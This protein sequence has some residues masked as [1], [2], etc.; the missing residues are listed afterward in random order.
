MIDQSLNLPSRFRYE[1]VVAKNPMEAGERRVIAELD[2][3]GCIRHF[4]VTHR[5]T[6]ENRNFILRIWWDDEKEPSVECP[7]PDFFGVHNDEVYYPINSCFLSVKDRGGFSCCF[8]MPF[9]KSARVEVEALEESTFIY[10]LDWHKYL[11]DAMEE[12]LRFHASWRR[13]NPA[14]AW[15]EDFFVIDAVGRGRLIGF[16]LGVRLRSDEHRWSHAGSENLY[17]DGEATGQD[18][19]VPHYLRAGG[20]ENSFDAGF[21]GVKHQA[22]THLYAGIP[23]LEYRDAGPALAR[24]VL[25]AYRFF[26]QDSLSFEKSLHFRWGSHA[27]DMCMT[28]YWYQTEP[29]R[30]SVQMPS[31]EDLV[32]GDWRGEVEIERGKYDLLTQI[33]SQASDAVPAS[34]DDGSWSLY[35]G[36]GALDS[37]ADAVPEG[38]RRMAHHGFIDFSHVFN[39]KSNISNVTWPANATAVTSLGMPGDGAATLHLSWAGKMKIRVNDEA[40]VDLGTHPTYRYTPVEVELRKGENILFVN[41]DNPE[42]GLHWGAFTFSCRVVSLGGRVVVPR[43]PR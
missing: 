3:P 15:S 1:R 41:L 21:G 20:G 16:S 18:G 5:R 27:N 25:S 13:E 35:G 39:V 19:I 33:G 7:L 22:D 26:V 38:I 10:T 24:H 30:P 40:I 9:A 29:H 6:G 42:P 31:Y 2:G 23:Y 12:D 28:S 14:P 4:Y 11:S 36:N 32:Y 8:P 37:R 34:P 43:Q 17:I